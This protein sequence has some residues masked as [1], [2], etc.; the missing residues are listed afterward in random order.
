[1][2]TGLGSD[3][4]DACSKDYVHMANIM[5]SKRYIRNQEGR[6]PLR[7]VC[8]NTRADCVLGMIVSAAKVQ[9]HALH[10]LHPGFADAFKQLQTMNAFKI[11]VP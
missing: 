10:C 7:I 6:T 11:R 2:T 3:N 1:M 5:S 8:C 9:Y 4:A